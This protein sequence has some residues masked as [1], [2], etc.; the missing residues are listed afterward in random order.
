MRIVTLNLWNI[1]PDWGKRCEVIDSFLCAENPDIVF[2]QEVSPRGPAGRLQFE[3]FSPTLRCRRYSAYR[4]SGLWK[5]REEGLAILSSHELINVQSKTLPLAPADMPRQLLTAFVLVDGNKLLLA[6]T[7]LAFSL[8]ATAARSAQVQ[9]CLQYISIAR[10]TDA[11]GIVF[12]GDFNSVPESSPIEQVLSGANRLVDPFRPM[13][14]ARGL[15]TFGSTNPLADPILGTDRWIDYIFVSDGLS[16][17][18]ADRVLD[19]VGGNGHWA[20]DHFGL[21]VDVRL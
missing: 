14:I 12:A 3:D 17:V 15:Y 13:N 10:A 2:L 21:L 19:R 5:G 9:A 20:S 18:R 6:N 16:V 8:Q 4:K 7:H 11:I 1:N